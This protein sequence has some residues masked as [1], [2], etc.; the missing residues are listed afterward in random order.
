MTIDHRHRGREVI[1]NIDI[2]IL[3]IDGDIVR[4]VSNP[5]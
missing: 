3:R 1:C 5:D 4:I 2:T